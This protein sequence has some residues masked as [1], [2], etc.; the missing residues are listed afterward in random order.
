MVMFG[1][2]LETIGVGLILPYISIIQNQDLIKQNNVIEKIYD[3]LLMNSEKE[4]LI[5]IGIGLI[6]FYL[7]K[8]IM[9]IFFQS[10]QFKFIYYIQ[11]KLANR[12]LKSYLYRPYVF[13]IQHNTA[14]LL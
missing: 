7:I 5:W 10:T 4:F 2:F 1:A 12:L 14:E 13:H 9:L 6:V 8:N 11:N 3:F